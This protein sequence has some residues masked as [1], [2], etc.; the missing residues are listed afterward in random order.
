MK[1]SRNIILL[2]PLC[3]AGSSALAQPPAIFTAAQVQRGQALYPRQCGACHGPDLEGGTGPALTG[4]DFRALAAGQN[5]TAASLLDIMRQTMP[6]DAPGID[7]DAD[8][9]DILAYML[10]RLGYPSGSETL[11]PDNPHLKDLKLAP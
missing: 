2:L 8:Y 6:Y 1:A 7:P 4:P 11:S 9:N 10:S 3:L 5:L